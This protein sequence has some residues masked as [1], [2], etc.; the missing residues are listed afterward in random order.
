M[1]LSILLADRAGRHDERCQAKY[2]KYWDQYCKI[3][4]YKMLPY[5]Y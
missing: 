4:P 1:Y 5:I 3:V 2:G